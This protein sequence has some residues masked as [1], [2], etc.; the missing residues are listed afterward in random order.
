MSNTKADK[1]R[2]DA[3]G[4]IRHFGGRIQLWRLLEKSGISLSIKTIEAWASRNS[5]PVSR[6]V[7]L[8]TLAE[9]IGKPL[10]LDSIITQNKA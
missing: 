3:K 10:T 1:N 2:L 6:L 5:I 9:K 4:V 8:V 7:E